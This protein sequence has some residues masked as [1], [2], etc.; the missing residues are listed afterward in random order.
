MFQQH[1]KN[2]IDLYYT[3]QDPGQMDAEVRR[4]THYWHVVKRFKSAYKSHLVIDTVY[5]GPD[6]DKPQRKPAW[7]R[8]Y[9][10]TPWDYKSY[11]TEQLIGDREGNGYDLGK[12]AKPK[13]PIV[14]S[15]NPGRLRGE[16]LK[17]MHPDVVTVRCHENSVRVPWNGDVNDVLS[18]LEGF[19]RAGFK[20]L[21]FAYSLEFEME[22][23]GERVRWTWSDYYRA[24][25]PIA[26]RLY[27]TW[28]GEAIPD[29]LQAGF[30]EVE[31]RGAPRVRGR[32]PRPA[33]TPQ[34]AR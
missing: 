34:P 30:E 4:L 31:A 5:Y 1:R 3:V 27:H 26:K 16:E 25:H 32:A 11:W 13:A 18:V 21:P 2:G 7:R 6:L 23:S 19:K 22:V 14:Y 33:R 29:E 20:V 17:Y 28:T 24:G 12:L 9:V 15:H 8:P 10:I